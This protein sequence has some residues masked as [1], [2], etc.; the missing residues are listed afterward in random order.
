MK[1]T[2]KTQSHSLTIT[3][4]FIHSHSLA[5]THTC[6]MSKYKNLI[7]DTRKQEIILKT[8]SVFL[9]CGAHWK[10]SALQ[11]GF[12]FSSVLPFVSVLRALRTKERTENKRE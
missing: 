10:N 6:D 4:V 8:F 2:S 5:L 1:I 12:G 11:I 3:L 7:Y 9:V